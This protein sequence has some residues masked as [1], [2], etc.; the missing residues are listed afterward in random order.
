MK[1]IC[2]CQSFIHPEKIK[3]LPGQ[4]QI[5]YRVG[6]YATFRRSLLLPLKD[7]T[8][9]AVELQLLNWRPSGQGDL[10]VQI[11]EWWAYLADILTFYSDRIANQAY[12][13]TADLP[14]SVQGLI[15]LLGYRPRPGIAARGVLAAIS[16]G[17]ESFTLPAGFQIQSKP[18]PGQKPQ[19][20]ELDTPTLIKSPVAIA[21]HPVPENLLLKDNSVLLQGTVTTVKADDQL[22]ILEKGWKGS[23]ND[24]KNNEIVIVDNNKNYEIVVVKEVKSEKDSQ[25]KI[26]T[27]IIFT[28]IPNLSINSQVEKYRLLKSSQTAHVWQHPTNDKIVITTNEIHLE[29]ISRQ[30]KKGDPVLLEVPDLLYGITLVSVTEYSEAIW[31]ANGNPANPSQPPSSP[32]PPLPFPLIPITHTK[33]KVQPE[34]AES[35]DIYKTSV[36][37]RYAWQEVGQ[38]IA[39]PAALFN[40][41]STK[42]NTAS[43]IVLPSG[44]NSVPILLE[45]ANGQ[46]IAA[47]ISG[48]ENSNTVKISDLSNSDI[49]LKTPLQLLLNLLPVSRGETVNNEILGSGNAGIAGQ[50]F[51]LQ[52][53]PLTYLFSA[54]SGGNYQST[55]QIWVNG[56]E[57]QEV[58]NF[59][60]QPADAKIFVTREDEN[61]KT[62]VQF[63]DGI[64]GARLPSGVNNIIAKYR[65]GSGKEAPEAGKLNV[66]VKPF[67]NLKEIRNP[68]A[69]GG[70]ADP[71]SYQEIRRYAPQ[72]VLTFGRAVSGNDYEIIATQ[73]PGVARAKAY[74]T[75]NGD[76]QRSLVIVY[77]GDDQNAVNAARLALRG[78]ADPNRPVKVE[79][80]I[81]IPVSLSL[82][83]QIDL[84]YIK[85][86]V[87]KFVRTALLEANQGLFGNNKIQIGA[88]I[89]D[90][91]IYATC[92]SV[93]GVK[94]VHVLKFSVNT[95]DSFVI[96]DKYR[97][98][99]GEG[100][101]YQLSAENLIIN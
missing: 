94:A 48:G 11:I 68:V 17:T 25:G 39:T 4:D 26:N 50:E 57:W 89:Y 49:N 35:W 77:V 80:A 1:E 47:K 23:N 45:D 81:A 66:I 61:Q 87:I 71:E 76:E 33:I 40:S 62:Y 98:D 3:N 75:W 42:L 58:P 54:N 24:N 82:T 78:A 15:Q 65:Y 79:K 64:N 34:L 32:P 63:G 56:I 2:P 29:A 96:E 30:I 67:P 28:N 7:A 44:K 36:L 60:Q 101:F 90:S 59:Y 84:K 19:I 38:L 13:R 73:V 85:E 55:L 43:P 9:Q 97:H 100:K 8:G 37:V 22:L 14:E 31:Y 72:S 52:K 53:S 12:L 46:G 69:V 10:A 18:G 16:K 95:N 70:G 51:V 88:S 86:D 41:S 92:L 99:P 20:F 93:S 6:D 21:A 83:L 5:S 91:Q 27:R 74:W